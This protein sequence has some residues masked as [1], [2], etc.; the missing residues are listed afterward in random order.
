[1]KNT[2]KLVVI[3][4]LAV[5]VLSACN[6]QVMVDSE[7]E[8]YTISI[9]NTEVETFEFLEVQNI[10]NLDD[11][12]E[13]EE[14]EE[15]ETEDI[16]ETVEIEKFEEVEEIENIISVGDIIDYTIVQVINENMP[17]L[18]IRLLG[19]WVEGWGW[20]GTT[21]M[22]RIH[23]LQVIDHDGRLIQEFDGL[24]SR[25]S[26]RF[27]SFGL[28]FAD[29]NFDGFLDMALRLDDGGSIRNAPHSFWLWD[30]QL[31]KFVYNQ[32]LSRMSHFE[33]VLIDEENQFVGTWWLGSGSG[34]IQG[35]SRLEYIDGVFVVVSRWEFEAIFSMGSDVLA[36]RFTR[37]DL[38]AGTEVITYET[39][40][41]R[42]V[43]ESLPI[44]EFV[45]SIGGLLD[46]SYEI[47]NPREVSITIRSDGDLIQHI[48]NLSQ[49][50]MFFTSGIILEDLTFNGYLDMR[51]KRWQDGAGGLLVTEYIWLWDNSIGQF[52]LNEQLMQIEYS[53]LSVCEEQI[54]IFNRG[55]DTYYYI[56]SFYEYQNGEFVLVSSER[57]LFDD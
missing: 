35:G 54:V 19:E 32:E 53:E 28:H 27:D 17:P 15:T 29:Y 49:S 31:G 21:T 42:Q 9:E 41:W 34:E 12:I 18:T 51:L 5:L 43:H 50:D 4:F 56:L 6:N 57:V 38:I 45:R 23:T 33:S 40:F 25:I 39:Y 20:G 46:E 30:N 11:V 8:T 36:R 44:F 48:P 16:E 52:V 37:N 55:G 1:M 7:I 26:P 14:V 24:H 13:P 3:T 22:P 10:N 2:I 47:P